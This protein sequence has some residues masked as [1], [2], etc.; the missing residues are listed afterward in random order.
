VLIQPPPAA[1]RSRSLRPPAAPSGTPLT[2]GPT[3]LE[4]T[5]REFV[6]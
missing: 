3:V 2:L 1:S 4:W 6:K 5:Q